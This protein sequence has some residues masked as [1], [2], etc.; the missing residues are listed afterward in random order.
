MFELLYDKRFLFLIALINFAAGFYSLSYYWPQLVASP[1][2]FW[3]FIADC[4]FYAILF[5]LNILL[6]IKGTPS[7][8]LSFISIIGNIKYGLWTIFVI[9]VSPAFPGNALFILSHLLLISEVILF[10]SL[11]NFK[12]KHVIFA[13][14]WFLANDYLDYVLLFHPPVADNVLQMVGLFSICCS[15]IIPLVVSVIFSADMPTKEETV[16]KSVKSKWG[17]KH[18]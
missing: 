15:I 17:T 3:I 4:P 13:L 2:M 6:L 1:A 7:R 9:L 5:G 8:L 14:V 18:K 10:Y 16:H 11:F 12:V